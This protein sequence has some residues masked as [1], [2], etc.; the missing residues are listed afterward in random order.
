MRIPIPDMVLHAKQI[1][2]RRS[3][4]SKRRFSAVHHH[5]KHHDHH[6]DHDHNHAVP[7]GYFAVYV[8]EESQEMKKR[9]V[10]PISYLKHPS[11]QD[12]LFKAAEE[13]GFDHA[14]GPITIPC[15]EEDFIGL[16]S[17]INS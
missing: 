6:D 7:K 14:M 16:T 12:L 13:F 8:G 3:S 17:C 9:F 11:F 5:H 15:A 1:I 4:G 2:H 10:V